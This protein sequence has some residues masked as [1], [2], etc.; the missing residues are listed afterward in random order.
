VIL[1]RPLFLRWR[2]RSLACLFFLRHN[3]VP[4]SLLPPTISLKLFVTYDP[5]PPIQRDSQVVRFV[6]LDVS[7]AKARFRNLSE[8]RLEVF[9]KGHGVFQ[10]LCTTIATKGALGIA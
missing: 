3:Y 6:P 4:T 1:G 10:Q 2:T 9:R 5:P 7:T 8:Q